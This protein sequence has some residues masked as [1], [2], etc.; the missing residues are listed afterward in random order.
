MFRGRLKSPS[1]FVP[2]KTVLKPTALRC[3]VFCCLCF[4]CFRF[5]TTLFSKRHWGRL[6]N[7]ENGEAVVAGWGGIQF[8]GVGAG[9]R[10]GM[11]G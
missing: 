9:S 8:V 3:A 10:V 2:T 7:R 6:K 1:L 11:D 5:Q 4:V